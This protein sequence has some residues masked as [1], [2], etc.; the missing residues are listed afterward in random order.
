MGTLSN[1]E[2]W[3]PRVPGV[4]FCRRAPR[5]VSPRPRPPPGPAL[6]RTI[7]RP[8][9]LRI[10][11]PAPSPPGLARR[12]APPWPSCSPGRAER[13]TQQV[14]RGRKPPTVPSRSDQPS[15][16]LRGRVSLSS[17]FQA[18]CQ[19]S[20]SNRG[21]LQQLTSQAVALCAGAKKGV[22]KTSAR[23]QRPSRSGAGLA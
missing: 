2:N 18:G 3:A 20:H 17:L 11:Q 10:E 6:G 16:T 22:P 14:A 15:P 19:V 8:L 4:S 13:A 21:P 23:V 12:A 7:H 9:L 1:R 5:D